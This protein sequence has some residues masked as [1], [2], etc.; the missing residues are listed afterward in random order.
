MPRTRTE[1]D[2]GRGLL[3][4]NR[5][6]PTMRGVRALTKPLWGRTAHVCEQQAQ[7]VV[8]L[9]DFAHVWETRPRA[10][11]R[12]P[13][14]M[15]CPAA[16]ESSAK[17]LRHHKC[18]LP[19][20]VRKRRRHHARCRGRSVALHSSLVRVVTWLG[21]S[22]HMGKRFYLRKCRLLSERYDTKSR[23]GPTIEYDNV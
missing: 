4:G 21:T 1:R 11:A 10:T 9:K 18:V 22:L 6:R 16:R 12:Q 5:H 7:E 20:G 8:L 13:P 2:A 17:T 3:R 23:D 15:G 14:A 19:L